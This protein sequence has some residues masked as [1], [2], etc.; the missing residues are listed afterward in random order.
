LSIRLP[1]TPAAAIGKSMETN[2]Y[3]ALIPPSATQAFV[4]L[5]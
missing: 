2:A 5:I 4:R 1:E 3:F